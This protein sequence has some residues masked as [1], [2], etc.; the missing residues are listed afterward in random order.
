MEGDAPDLECVLALVDGLELD[1]KHVSLVVNCTI[2]DE[3][4][5]TDTLSNTLL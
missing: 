3:K 1:V 2:T 4:V 5:L